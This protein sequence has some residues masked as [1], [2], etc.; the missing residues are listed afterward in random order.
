MLK[1]YLEQADVGSIDLPK[2]FGR[3]RRIKSSN[4]KSKDKMKYEKSCYA[5]R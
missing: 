3:R 2:N 1:E 5:E 4:L